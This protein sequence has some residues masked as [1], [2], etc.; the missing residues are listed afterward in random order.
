[1]SAN[2]ECYAFA[3]SFSGALDWIAH[4]EKLAHQFFGFETECAA[5]TGNEKCRL[6]FRSTKIS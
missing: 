1:L 2:T 6:E 5:Q 4:S 3:G